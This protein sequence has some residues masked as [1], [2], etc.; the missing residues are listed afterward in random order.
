MKTY[1]YNEPEYDDVGNIVG[2]LVYTLTE[3]EIIDS[4]YVHWSREMCHQRKDH[5]VT[6]DNC[7]DDW[8]AVNWA[9]E[10]NND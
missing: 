6:K 7:I 4:Y 9:W 3:E 2:N 5:L 10:V 8:V 1:S